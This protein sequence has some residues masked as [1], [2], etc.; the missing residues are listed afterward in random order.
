ME[1]TL[2]DFVITP[3][4]GTHFFQNLT[5]LGIGYFTVNHAVNKGFI[6]WDWLSRMEA[7][8]ETRF[9]RCVR[10]NDPLDIRIDGRSQR[11][12]VLKPAGDGG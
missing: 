7:A 8:E 6:D 10:L 12:V 9:V 11:G 1:T 3:S 4:Q 5:S 2:K